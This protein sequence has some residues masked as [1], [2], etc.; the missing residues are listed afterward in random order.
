MCLIIIFTDKMSASNNT[1]DE[2][3]CRIW[4][5]SLELLESLDRDIEDISERFAILS[6]EDLST[7]EKYVDWRESLGQDIEDISTR[8]ACLSIDEQHVDWKESLDQK[9]ED[10]SERFARLSIDE[11]P[12]DTNY[13]TT[14]PTDDYTPIDGDTTPNTSA[15]TEE[16]KYRCPCIDEECDGSCG[17]QSCGRC[18]DVCRCCRHSRY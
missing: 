9:F 11:S 7:E 3:Q 10:I 12:P 1:I 14:T 16:Y 6:T 5:E 8:I 17:V 15:Y 18:I 13:C 2:E 4:K